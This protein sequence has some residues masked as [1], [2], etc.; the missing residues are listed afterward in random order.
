MHDLKVFRLDNENLL[1]AQFIRMT[2]E[3]DFV[4]TNPRIIENVP[5]TGESLSCALNGYADKEVTI[6][7]HHVL[8]HGLACD[9]IAEWFHV[10]V[11]HSDS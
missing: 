2:P 3:G 1:L 6:N 7:R 11:Y 9:R 10:V 8:M 4:V 5:G